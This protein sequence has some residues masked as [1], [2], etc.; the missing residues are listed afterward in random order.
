MA[1]TAS[2]SLAHVILSALEG[3]F[4]FARAARNTEALDACGEAMATLVEAALA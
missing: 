4:V 2:R 3:A 1:K